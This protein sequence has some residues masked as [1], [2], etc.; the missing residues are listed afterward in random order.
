MPKVLYFTNDFSAE[1]IQKAKDEN[2]V[3]RDVRAYDEDDFVEACDSV[4]GDVPEAYKE[5]Y[6]V[7]DI[8]PAT[9]P[10]PTVI[11]MRQELEDAEYELDGRLGDKKITAIYREFKEA[12]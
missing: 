7:L 12:E 2:L 8:V 3:M 11:E 9:K 4:T 6:E 5:K 10:L 1:N